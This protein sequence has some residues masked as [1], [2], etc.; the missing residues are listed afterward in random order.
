MR[1]FHNGTT[2]SGRQVLWR[3]CSITSRLAQRSDLLKAE[4]GKA[5]TVDECLLAIGQSPN[6]R[7]LQQQALWAI[8]YCCLHTTIRTRLMGPQEEKGK[9][10]KSDDQAKTPKKQQPNN[11]VRILAVLIV[12]RKQVFV[13]RYVWLCI[14]SDINH[15]LS[16][17][18]WV[19]SFSIHVLM[20]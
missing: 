3:G 18:K 20:F 7:P 8:H 5:E 11:L 2:R 1:T 6:D 9:G 13:S 16:T 12:L 4:L 14:C 10:N 17:Q 15:P 19:F